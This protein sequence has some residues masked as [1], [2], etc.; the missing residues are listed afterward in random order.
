EFYNG[1]FTSFYDILRISMKDSTSLLKNVFDDF[2]SLPIAHR[3]TLFKNFYSKF[4][5]VECVYFTMKHFK[6]DESMYVASIITVADINNMDQWMSDDKNFKNK[7]AFKS[8][9]QGFSKEYYDLFTPMMK[10]DVMTDREFY[11][12]AVLNYCD[13]DTLDLPEEVITITQ[14]TRAKVFEELQD[15]YRNALNL[16]DFSKRLGNLMT[17]AHGFGEA[18]RLMNKEMQMYSTMFDIYSDD[19]FFREIFSE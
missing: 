19:S 13:V 16:H 5:M 12:L 2:D 7:D 4:S 11:A 17:M 14:A 3:V 6:D 9:C 18:A 15:Y 10:M 1:N 8:S